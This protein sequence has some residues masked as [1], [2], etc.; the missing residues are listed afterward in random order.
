MR[1]LDRF[2]DWLDAGDSDIKSISRFFIFVVGLT[3]LIA[4]LLGLV[5]ILFAVAWIP[6][7][8]VFTYAGYRWVRWAL[9]S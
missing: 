2:D 9:R 3:A 8:T 1:L 7:A 6:T 4:A 5:V